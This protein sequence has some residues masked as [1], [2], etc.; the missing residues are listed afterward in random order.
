MTSWDVLTENR[1]HVS[2][3]ERVFK[4]KGLQ[5]C[6]DTTYPTSTSG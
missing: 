1:T 2:I 6:V 4:G 5:F 3:D